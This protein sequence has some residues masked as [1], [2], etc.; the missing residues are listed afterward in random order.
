MTSSSLGKQYNRRHSRVLVPLPRAKNYRA[1]TS[2]GKLIHA[3]YEKQDGHRRYMVTVCQ[4]N[5][6]TAEQ[7]KPRRN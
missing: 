2:A 5:I 1:R 4:A 7:L 6:T 3:A